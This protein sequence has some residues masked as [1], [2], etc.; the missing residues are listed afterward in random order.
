MH[1]HV[2]ILVFS[3]NFIKE[4]LFPKFKFPQNAKLITFLFFQKYAKFRVLHMKIAP[5]TTTTHRVVEVIHGPSPTQVMVLHNPVVVV[6]SAP[7][8]GEGSVTLI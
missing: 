4:I 1:Q 3:F 6:R 2:S 8:T 5:A 7:R